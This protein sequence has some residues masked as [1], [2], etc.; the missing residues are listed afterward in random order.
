MLNT[1]YSVVRSPN[2]YLEDLIYSA[3]VKMQE[4]CGTCSKLVEGDEALWCEG[5]EIWFHRTC[6]MMSKTTFKKLEK[7]KDSWY[8]SSCP[9]VKTKDNNAK[10]VAKGSGSN[11]SLTLEDI[12]NK[13][14]DMQE[15]YNKLFKRYEEQIRI[16]EEL[17]K[18]I[19]S[20]RKH[21]NDR[22]QHDL[23]N[24]LI[25]HGIPFKENEKVDTIVST[26]QTVLKLNQGTVIKAYRLGNT[27][28]ERAKP[29]RVILRNSEVKKKLV[30]GKEGNPGHDSS[31]WG[32]GN[33]NA[34]IHK[35]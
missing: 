13:L 17:Q 35:S 7:S 11:G 20:I 2:R 14:M 30:T 26:I 18:E 1:G 6:L 3:I 29:I 27:T 8:C 4:D 16:N 34:Y 12:M 19:K 22:E 25:I 28:D 5:C 31:F 15:G 23:N 10:N 32:T 9:K 24:N 21:I 33:C